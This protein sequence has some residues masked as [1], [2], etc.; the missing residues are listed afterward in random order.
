M[1]N[2]KSS[3][4]IKRLI[5]SFL[6]PAK[7]KTHGRPIYAKDA[8]VC[9]LNVVEKDQ[10]FWSLASQIRVRTNHFVST[11]ASKAL[12]SKDYAFAAFLQQPQS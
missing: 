2:G 4:E 10:E 7:T 3:D 8:R 5:A 11:M 6:T 1:M 9:G 12:E